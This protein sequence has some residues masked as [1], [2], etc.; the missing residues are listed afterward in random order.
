MIRI[1]IADDHQ[2]VVDGI[3][4]I[5]EGLE[6]IVVVGGAAS[7]EETLRQLARFEVDVLL[8]DINMAGMNGVQVAKRLKEEEHP[9]RIL[10]LTM[11]NNPQFTKQLIEIGVL[12]CLMK[13]SGKQEMIRAIKEVHAGQRY[14][15][16]EITNTL[17][18]SIDKS[19]KATQKAELT[20]REIEVLKLIANELTTNEIAEELFISTHT[21]ETHRKN[22]LS[23]LGFK[24]SAGLARFAAKNGLV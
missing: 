9:V 1:F 21:V 4:S 20:K 12:G 5:L 16:A 3:R 18:D 6:G 14:Y 15:G 24:N 13:N 19:Q 23:K 17:F 11:H 22:L 7:G 2:I 10:V 8:L